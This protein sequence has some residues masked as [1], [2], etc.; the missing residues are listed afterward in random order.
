MP[1]DQLRDIIEDLSKTIRTN[2]SF[3]VFGDIGF[4][5]IVFGNKKYG[6]R[7]I[8]HRR[9]EERIQKTQVSIPVKQSIEETAV[10]LIKAVDNIRTAPSKALK[11]GNTWEFRKDGIVAIVRRDRTNK[12]RYLLTGFADNRDKIK[13]ATVTIAAV[14]A[15]Y[16]YTPE[17]ADLYA[18]VGAVIASDFNVSVP[19]LDV[20]C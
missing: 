2:N 8:I 9:F 12:Y 4:V 20:N 15:K 16:R 5:E 10:V 11:S 19:E 18:Q 3:V 1:K 7:H 17:F 14:N 13:E 6:L